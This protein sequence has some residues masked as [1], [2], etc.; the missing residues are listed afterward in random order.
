M[1]VASGCLDNKGARIGSER[2]GDQRGEILQQDAN[3]LKRRADLTWTMV[4]ERLCDAFNEDSNNVTPSQFVV[5]RDS[6]E[7]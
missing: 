2:F 7:S 6:V 3:G 5:K 1:L 4:L